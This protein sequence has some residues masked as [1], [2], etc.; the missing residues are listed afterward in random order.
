MS[1][2]VVDVDRFYADVLWELGELARL[3]G[4]AVGSAAVVKR[5]ALAHGVAAA[6]RLP[7]PRL[8][9]SQQQAFGVAGVS[10]ERARR[11]VPRGR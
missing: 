5:V 9:R 1:S 6:E 7:L 11:A 2:P 10:R 4:S 8:T 3:G